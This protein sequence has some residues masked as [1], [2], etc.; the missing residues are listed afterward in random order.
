MLNDSQIY[1]IVDIEADGPVP[2][3]HSM[4]SIGAVASTPEQEVSSFYK[5]LLPLEDAQQHPETLDWWHKHPEAWAEA[6]ADAQPADVVIREFQR[7][8]AGLGAEPVFVA[9]P[10]VLDFGFMHWYLHKFL[11]DNPFMDYS[12]I[13]RT[14]DLAS[15]AAGKYNLPLD[16]A[17]R[18]QLPDVLT[19]GM[20]E[21]THR[22][23]DDARGY[24][25]LLRNILKHDQ[26]EE[27]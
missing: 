14:L 1:V 24:G 18:M 21:H 4:L 16:K 25:V 3:V 27:V 13:Q 12:S 17:R 8:V 7:W 11:G 2:G 19:A 15:L 9:S 23:I 10:L 6:T 26:L 20:P 5:K 22:A